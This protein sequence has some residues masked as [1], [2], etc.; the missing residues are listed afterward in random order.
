MLDVPQMNGGHRG[1]QSE[2]LG[3]PNKVRFGSSPGT[4]GTSNGRALS[5]DNVN[6]NKEGLVAMYMDTDKLNSSLGF[7]GLKVGGESTQ[8]TPQAPSSND[9]MT[10]SPSVRSL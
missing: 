9:N 5:E 4:V 8:A 10:G 2:S 6:M 3:L 7:Y 1:A